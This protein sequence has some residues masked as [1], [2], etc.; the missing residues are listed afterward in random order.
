MKTKIWLFAGL[1]AASALAGCNG[2]SNDNDNDS[3]DQAAGTSQPSRQES[4][5]GGQQVVDD[6][7]SV[8]RASGNLQ[9]EPTQ[10]LLSD[11]TA[12]L[13]TLGIEVEYSHCGNDGLAHIQS[14]GAA[15]GSIHVHQIH[16]DD[17]QVALDA[18]YASL[19]ELDNSI[20]TPCPESEDNESSA[21]SSF[22]LE[23]LYGRA[24]IAD[25][26]GLTLDT[27]CPSCSHPGYFL[28]DDSELQ[29]T[30][31]ETGSDQPQTAQYQVIDNQIVLPSVEV[32]LTLSP[33]DSFV[34][35]EQGT[36]YNYWQHSLF[37]KTFEGAPL[38]DCND[39][40]LC[41]SG[42]FRFDSAT[43]TVD[44]AFPG[45]DIIESD[46]YSIDGDNVSLLSSG[47][48]FVYSELDGTL[49]DEFGQLFFLAEE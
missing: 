14:C 37:G 29:V 36:Q 27:S 22:D 18:G 1:F 45:S 16:Q 28:F 47:I 42:F 24:F 39:P 19:S 26:T 49:Q 46:V 38:D 15:D 20:E 23:R 34:Q 13:D 40:E 48:V 31:L 7:V 8:Y 35:D 25:T 12:V 17:L 2:G 30:Y 10:F 33:D 32:S 5:N 6:V 41:G 43:L 4:E 9:C 44:Y 3:A 11:S 21:E